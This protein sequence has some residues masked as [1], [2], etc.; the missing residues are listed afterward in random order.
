MR[1]MYR[2]IILSLLLSAF[3]FCAK[4]NTPIHKDRWMEIDLYWFKK[5]E[6]KASSE[7]FWS[8][9]Y[10]LFANI[11]GEKGVIINIG[12]LMDYI[13]EWNGSLDAPIP[14]AKGMTV[15]KQFKDE[16]YILGNTE[17]RMT[18]WKNRFS[19]ARKPGTVEYDNWTYRDLKNFIVIFKQ[20]AAKHGIRDIKVGSFVLGWQS[21]YEGNSSRFA[22]KH[23]CAYS[24]EKPFTPFNPTCILNHDKTRYGAYP[25]GIPDDLPVTK[26][27][28]NQWGDFSKTIG[29]DAIVLRD[30]VIGQGIYSRTGPFGKTASDDPDELKRWSNAYADLVR[31][32]KQANP[33]A[34]VIGYS[35][36]ATTVGDWRVNCFDLESIANEGFL[37]AY[38]DQSWAGAWNE[39]GQRPST[40]WNDQHMGWTFQLSY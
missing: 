7:E 10:P 17:Q 31:Y 12:W 15:W 32:T 25:R 1:F 29:L 35:C 2:K 19:N 8:R 11:S 33:K 18:H 34:L 36:G 27:F 21:I 16:G 39:V 13:L 6:M 38:I 3:V 9:M 5:A 28:G 22:V 37:D 20:A 24:S 26:F 40:F 30:A 4:A 23:P 14:L